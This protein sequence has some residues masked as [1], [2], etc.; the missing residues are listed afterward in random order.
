VFTSK[1][2][3]PTLSFSA[4][5]RGHTDEQAHKETATRLNGTKPTATSHQET[6]QSV[7]APSVNNDTHDMIRVITIVQQIMTELKGAVSEEAKVLAITKIL[8]KL[9]NKDGK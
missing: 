1:P 5:F 2:V 7:L 6:S 8:V 4:A 9:M 3:K